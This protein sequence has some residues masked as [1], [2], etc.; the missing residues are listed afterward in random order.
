M[1]NR[2]R[3][4]VIR[5]VYTKGIFFMY[6]WE[7]EQRIINIWVVCD[8]NPKLLAVWTFL[9]LRCSSSTESGRLFC[10]N[11]HTAK[12]F[13]V[14]SQAPRS[15][16]GVSRNWVLLSSKHT[17]L[18][19]RSEWLHST[20]VWNNAAVRDCRLMITIELAYITWNKNNTAK[21]TNLKHHE[22]QFFFI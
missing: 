20:H 2:L 12:C 7:S 21:Y 1:Y 4:F 16:G 5:R 9:C 6:M 8:L 10:T 22:L 3:V 13:A 11:T 18:Q 17:R 15:R 19:Q 14:S